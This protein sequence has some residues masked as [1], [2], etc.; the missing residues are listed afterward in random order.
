[1]IR[2]IFTFILTFH[3]TYALFAQERNSDEIF[4][5]LSNIKPKGIFSSDSI[6]L[7]QSVYYSLSL[8]YAPNLQ[9]L[10]PD[11]THNFAPFEL[12]KRQYFNTKTN[13]NGSLDSVVYELS[14]FE[15]NK[16]QK[17]SLPIYVVME[18]DCTTIFTEADSLILREM[19]KTKELDKIKPKPQLDLAKTSD[20]FNYPYLI[21]SILGVLLVILFVWGILGKQIRQ[22]YFLFQFQNRQSKFIKDFNRLTFKVVEKQSSE[23]IEKAL[24]LWKKH[25]EYLENKPFSTYTSKEIGQVIPDKELVKSLKNIDKAIYG[26]D[27]SGEVESAFGKLKNFSIIT[28]EQRQ[29]KLRNA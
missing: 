29:E 11:S 17:L 14:T 5:D 22:N 18:K 27:I 20:Y 21:A 28:F 3:F 19:I 7:G 13:K 8:R 2:K 9:V 25:L 6:G 12:K 4:L 24:T 10:F 1:M 15:I 16:V 23:N 26:K